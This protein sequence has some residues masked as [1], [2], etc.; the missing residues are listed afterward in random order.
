[1]EKNFGEIE[2]NFWKLLI[3]RVIPATQSWLSTYVKD[4]HLELSISNLNDCIQMALR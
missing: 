1:M 3:Q 4:K 2:Y